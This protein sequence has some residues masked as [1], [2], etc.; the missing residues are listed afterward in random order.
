M[1][2]LTQRVGGTARL[3]A[4]VAVTALVLG[5]T[6]AVAA[7]LITGKDIKNGSIASKDLNKKLR[8]KIK[9]SGTAGAPGQTG[10]A[11]APGAPGAP[12]DGR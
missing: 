5:G 8:K 2:R 7:Q 3:I 9:K 12:G 10:P 4:I 11:G 1:K 6:G